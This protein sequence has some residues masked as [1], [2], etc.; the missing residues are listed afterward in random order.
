MS[1]E[2]IDATVADYRSGHLPPHLYALALGMAWAADE[3]GE[4]WATDEQLAALE[5]HVTM[6]GWALAHLWHEPRTLF[7]TWAHLR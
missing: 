7:S 6:L 2:A 4:L 3:D 5:A 1:A